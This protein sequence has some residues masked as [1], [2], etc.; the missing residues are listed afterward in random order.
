MNDPVS[1]Q[2]SDEFKAW[3]FALP[4]VLRKRMK[5]SDC[6][7]GWNAGWYSAMTKQ[8]GKIGGNS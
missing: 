5:M 1:Y 4:E 6:M 7:V 8:T 3:W 2:T